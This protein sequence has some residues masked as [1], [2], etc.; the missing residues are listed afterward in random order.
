MTRVATFQNSQSALL[1][2]QRAQA[3]E[4]A[5]GQAVSSGKKG[6][7]LRAFGRAAEGV[8]ALKTV[9]ARVT[10]WLDQG[11][12]LQG[13]LEMQDLMLN[14]VSDAAADARQAMLE[15]LA[16]DR[17]DGFA[18]AMQAAF[19]KAA[20]ALNARH[21]GRYLFAGA[22]LE[23]P[24]FE[25]GR[26]ADLTGVPAAADLF[27]NDGFRAGTRLGEA[28]SLQTGELASE[29]GGPLMDAFRRVQ[30][31]LEGPD[32]ALG[33]PLTAA[34][35]AFL[36][37]EV[38]GLKQAQDGVIDV[39]A[40]NGAVQRRLDDALADLVGRDKTLKGLIG[41]RTDVDMTE[42]VADLQ[43]AQVAVQ[44]SAQVFAALRGSSLLDLLPL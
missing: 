18:A 35:K 37:S 36:E 29:I 12:Q 9:H 39:A 28:V 10:T 25:A 11:R 13:R 22:R 17:G 27:N 4:F 20:E 19:S 1:N 6:D 24:P 26:M 8:V 41:A 14:R 3:R 21:D 5:A 2:L 15:A 7:D 32:G 43:A 44:A 34:Q 31:F 33:H 16:H 42:A 38:A 30:A 23:E 40:R